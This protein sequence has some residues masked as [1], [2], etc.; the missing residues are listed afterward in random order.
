MF[1]C[2]G[3]VGVEDFRR[4]VRGWGCVRSV[5]ILFGN[6]SGSGKNFLTKFIFLNWIYLFF[7]FKW[8]VVEIVGDF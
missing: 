7:V 8:N 4:E 1:F 3:E 5:V 6:V 2:K